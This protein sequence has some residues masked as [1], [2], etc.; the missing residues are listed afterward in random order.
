MLVTATTVNAQPDLC[1]YEMGVFGS[2]FIYQ[3]DLSPSRLGSYR[4]MQPGFSF[5][6]NRNLNAAYTLRVNFA[7]GRLVGDD[8]KFALPVWRRFRNFKFTS[9]VTEISALIVWHPFEWINTER[10]RNF[11]PYAFGGVGISFLKIKQDYSGLVASHFPA[12]NIAV[13]LAVDQQHGSPSVIPVIPVGIGLRYA[14][15]DKISVFAESSYRFLFTD[16]I[17]SYSRS[18]NPKQK[19]SY[20]S[21]SVGVIFH[22][23]KKRN[24][25]CPVV[26]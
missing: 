22:F 21:H 10:I 15:S 6:I 2:L 5:F 26:K 17:D 4:T 13:H 24:L 16:Y 14:V 1:K 9:P 7:R 25:D 12:E 19:D 18:A 11:S 23:G 8:S 20:H 3:G